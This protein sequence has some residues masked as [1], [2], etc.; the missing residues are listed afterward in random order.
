[1]EKDLRYRFLLFQN[2]KIRKTIFWLILAL[3]FF[4]ALI[5]IIIFPFKKK[6]AEKYNYLTVGICGCVN[7]RGVYRL[8]ENSDLATLIYYAKGVSSRGDIRNLDLD[9]VLVNNSVYSIPCRKAELDTSKIDIT[10]NHK[11]KIDTVD[12]KLTNFLYVGFPAVYFL[13]QYST[14]HKL[15][16]VIYL[17]HSSVFLNNDYRLI[18]LFFTLGIDQTMDILQKSLNQRID[19]Y[20]I[21]NKFSFIKMINELGGL[22]LDIDASFAS[23]YNLDTRTQIL[24]GELCY[25]YIRFIDKKHY[26]SAGKSESYKDLKLKIKNIQLAYTQRQMRQK[27]VIQALYKK[28]NFDDLQ[29]NISTIKEIINEG[30]VNT[31]ISFKDAIWIFRGL[32]KGSKLS[33][34]TLPG[35]YKES[36]NSTY[37]IPSGP[38]FE[39]LRRRQVRGLFE[40]NKENNEQILY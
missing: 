22:K 29:S 21:Q 6:Y 3:L 9:Q 33:F 12:Q 36:G 4:T 18:D 24:E 20:Y 16:N 13:I 23:A 26:Y 40:L 25:E 39:M 28:F 2:Y 7:D 32:M 1:L 34:G 31:S 17:P 10:V 30:T 14:T 15:I 19:H 35:Y 37:Y 5:F 38:G 11:A 27:K 8:P